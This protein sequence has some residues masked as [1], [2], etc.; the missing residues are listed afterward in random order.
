MRGAGTCNAIAKACG[1]SPKG[2]R[3]S[4]RRISPGWIGRIPFT[5]G[6]MGLSKSMVIND[7]NLE[8]IAIFEVKADPPLIIDAYAVTASTIALQPLQT[9]IWR[10]S[11]IV[12][13][14]GP[15]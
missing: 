14:R 13:P 12:D 8:G 1:V 4:S 9:V 11:E 2:M 10:N 3:N 5:M 6:I 15:V 7:F